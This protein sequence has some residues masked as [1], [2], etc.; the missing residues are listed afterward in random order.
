MNDLD[1]YKIK[2]D[3]EEAIK[4]LEEINSY[5]TLCKCK[6]FFEKCNSE[7]INGEVFFAARKNNYVT[8]FDVLLSDGTKISEIILEGNW[9]NVTEE[10]QAVFTETYIAE[11]KKL[12]AFL[13]EKICQAEI[14]EKKFQKTMKLFQVFSVFVLVLLI[15]LIAAK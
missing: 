1:Y 14:A 7:V 5:T 6:D 4:S 8:I 11:S 3:T 12:I 9:D 15:V 2:N 10:S 13:D